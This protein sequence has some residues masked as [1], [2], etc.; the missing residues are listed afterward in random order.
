MEQ[1]LVPDR[2]EY[3]I[4][5]LFDNRLLQ[6]EF[7]HRCECR[8]QTF[9]YVFVWR[10]SKLIQNSNDGTVSS[11]SLIQN[12]FDGN[13]RWQS[14]GTLDFNAI[15]ET[16]NVN[17]ISDAVIAMNNRIRDNLVQCFRWILN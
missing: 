6:P 3:S 2:N 13:V 15:V 17:I 1:W 10:V 11:E 12:V 7:V 9:A 16:S 5:L 14:T 4:F 8:V